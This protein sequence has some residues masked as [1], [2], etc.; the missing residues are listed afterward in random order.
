MDA[1]FQFGQRVRAGA[2]LCLF[3]IMPTVPGSLADPLPPAPPPEAL[4][5]FETLVNLTRSLQ[6]ND[7]AALSAPAL[8]R[9][10]AAW[11]VLEDHLPITG[12]CSAFHIPYRTPLV[13]A[14][15]DGRTT[16]VGFPLVTLAGGGHV[17]PFLGTE[18]VGFSLE[19]R[20]VC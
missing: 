8:A 19:G 5:A 18:I 9:F 13:A 10:A 6:G 3:V 4:Q 1:C 15:A 17:A 2:L 20:A 14:A 11:A 12:F 16:M 7:T